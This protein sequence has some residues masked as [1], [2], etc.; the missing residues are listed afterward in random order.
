MAAKVIVATLSVVIAVLLGIQQFRSNRHMKE[1]MRRGRISRAIEDAKAKNKNKITL[2]API[3]YYAGVNTLDEGLASYTTL[4]AEPISRHSWIN[5]TSGEIET[6]YKLHVVDF[7]SQPKNMKCSD[8]SSTKYVPAELQ[9]IKS[10]EIVIRRNTGTVVADEVEVTSIDLLYPEFK[11]H[12]QYLFFLSYDGE[13]RVGTIELGA[14]GVSAIGTNGQVTP[15][16][17]KSNR[18]NK[19]LTSRYGDD[20]SQIRAELKFRR[21]PE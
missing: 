9:P 17:E 19:Q 4:I 10:D 7:L 13:T 6:W 8:C 21:F 11:L 16:S 5:Q 12:Q 18:L 1:D 14:A 20:I 2:P 15:I 3:P